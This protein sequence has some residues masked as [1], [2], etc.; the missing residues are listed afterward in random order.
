MS[1]PVLVRWLD[2]IDMAILSYLMPMY[3]GYLAFNQSSYFK[4]QGIESATR[5]DIEF[6]SI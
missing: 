3:L 5:E 1:I 6:R 4:L 2:R